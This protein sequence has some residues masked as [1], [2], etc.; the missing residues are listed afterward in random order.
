MVSTILLGAFAAN[1]HFESAASLLHFTNTFPSVH[2]DIDHRT[3]L[4]V[5]KWSTLHV[6]LKFV[7]IGEIRSNLL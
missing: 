2:R 1:I 6:A 5:S 3:S 7:R 4:C